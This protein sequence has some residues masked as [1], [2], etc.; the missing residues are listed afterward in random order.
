MGGK[1]IGQ[2]TCRN[3]VI[4]NIAGERQERESESERERDIRSDW[5]TREEII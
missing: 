2:E 4:N 1:E 3:E 5:R